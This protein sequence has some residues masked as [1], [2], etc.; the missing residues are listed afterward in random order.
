MSD[1]LAETETGPPSVT[2]AGAVIAQNAGLAHGAAWVIA[3]TAG[4][5]GWEAICCSQLAGVPRWTWSHNSG[6]P[7]GNIWPLSRSVA[8]SLTRNSF[9]RAREYT[10]T[11]YASSRPLSLPRRASARAVRAEDAA[12]PRF[13]PEDRAAPRALVEVHASVGWHGLRLLVAAV[14][15]R[16]RGRENCHARVLRACARGTPIT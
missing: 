6:R 16:Q 5:D 10:M 1:S 11:P 13:G 2:T 4:P 9:M 15:T 3:P 14:R 12:I 7:T 8:T